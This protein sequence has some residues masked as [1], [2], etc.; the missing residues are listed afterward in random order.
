V[1]NRSAIDLRTNELIC[2]SVDGIDSPVL[3]GNM[4]EFLQQTTEK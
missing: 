2:F 1:E 4:A 3:M